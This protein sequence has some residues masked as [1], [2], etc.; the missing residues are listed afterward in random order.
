MR[1]PDPAF[2]DPRLAALY[3]VFDADRGDLDAYVAIADEVAARS[4]VDVG[5]GTGSLAVRLAAL[6][7]DV[8]GV[9]PAGAS[10]DVARAK[11]YAER[12]TWRQGDATVLQDLQLATDLAVMTGNVAQVFVSD[13]DWALTLDAVHGC[14]RPGGWFAFETR[15]PEARDWE[16]WD[17]APETVDVPDGSTVLVT[18]TVTRSDLPLIT[19]DSTTT[20]DGEVVRSSSTLRFRSRAEVEADLS[21]HGFEVVDVRDAPDRPGKELVFLA[22]RSQSPRP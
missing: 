16:H 8:V 10:L 14:L 19:F 21:D 11:P 15:R 18:R 4:V 7:R 22:R 12:V 9:D 17:L 2:A 5:C 20:L 6:G 1:P 13:E 3:D